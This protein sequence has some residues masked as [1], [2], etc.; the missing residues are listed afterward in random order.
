[1]AKSENNAVKRLKT[2]TPMKSLLKFVVYV[3]GLGV[4]VLACKEEERKPVTSGEKPSKVQEYEVKNFAGGADIIYTVPDEH[5]AYVVAAYEIK[6]GVRREARSSKYT[7]K[8]TVEGFPVEGEYEVTLYTVGRNEQR[9][10]PIT[11]LVNPSRPPVLLTFETLNISADFGGITIQGENELEGELAYEV[12]SR[13]DKGEWDAVSQYYSGI[14]NVNWSVRGLEAKEYELG[15][16]VRDR[17]LNYSDTLFVTVTPYNEFMIDMSNFTETNL[18]GDETRLEGTRRM[19]YLFD[20]RKLS[21][22]YAYYTQA[23]TGMPQR[24]TV[25]LQG[26][27]KL[28]RIINWQNVTNETIA[29]NSSNPKRFRVWGSMEPN[30]DGSLDDTWYLLGE[31]E[32]IKP[33]GSPIGTNTQED[34]ERARAGDEYVFNRDIPPVRYIRIETLEVWGNTGRVYY[35]ELEIYGDHAD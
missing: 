17:W 6:P 26:T 31:F 19:S 8:I 16:F 35:T 7:S 30:P 14:R 20:G 23:G 32:N 27:Y 33:S 21:H 1:M 10:E 28:S 5:V 18:P 3:A 15:V 2:N 9:S 13:N 22:T 25:F 4:S 12:I 24:F 34:N 29:Y 11:V